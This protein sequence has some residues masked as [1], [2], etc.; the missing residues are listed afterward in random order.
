MNRRKGLSQV[1]SII[2]AAMVLMMTG[3]T[4]TVMT[5]G[6]LS[7]LFSGVSQSGCVQTAKSKCSVGGSITPPSSCYT[8]GDEGPEPI[9]NAPSWVKDN[10][11]KNVDCDEVNTGSTGSGTN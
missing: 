3:L 7:D 11:N 8:S 10:P 1:L 5:Q 2:V 6:G 9:A 4:L